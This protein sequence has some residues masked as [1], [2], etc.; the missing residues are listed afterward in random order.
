MVHEL[1]ELDFGEIGLLV[2]GIGKH[3]VNRVVR[4]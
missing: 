4:R 2:F 1:L 3:E